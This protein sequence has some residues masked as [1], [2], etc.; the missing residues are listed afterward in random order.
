MLALKWVQANI[1]GF[2]GDTNRVTIFGASAGAISVSL[3]L[4]SPLSKGLFH[5]A[6]IQSSASSSPLYNGKVA[7][8]KQ[9]ELF[10]KATNCSL[11]PDLVECVHAKTM[12][13]ILLGQNGITLLDSYVGQ[14]DIVGPIVDGQFL[15]DLPETLYKS[16][17]FHS[18]VDV[19]AGFTSSEGAMAAMVIPYDQVK[20]G[21]EQ[22]MFEFAVRNG[23]IYAREKSKIIEDLILFQYTNRADPNNKVA[24]RQLMIDSFS[25]SSVVSHIMLEAK[26]LGKVSI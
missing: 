23:M 3:H 2:G 18:G 7:K 1:A 21:I 13:D 11:G 20:D 26:A 25:D 24:A 17:Q 14:Q 22:E 8:P 16:G 4:I 10:S 15:P 19:L 9:L 5:R 12:E 6:I